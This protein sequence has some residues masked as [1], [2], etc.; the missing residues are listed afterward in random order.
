LPEDPTLHVSY[1]VALLE[2]GPHTRRGRPVLARGSR[3]IRLACARA[4]LLA[5]AQ[6]RLASDTR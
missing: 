6:T 5:A 2:R 3:S 1:G 4:M